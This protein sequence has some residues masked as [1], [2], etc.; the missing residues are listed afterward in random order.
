MN[1]LT[2]YYG[3]RDKISSVDLI[4]WR[5]NK[6]IGETIRWVTGQNVNHTSG[7]VWPQFLTGFPSAHVESSDPRLY[8]YEAAAEGMRLTYLSEALSKF[9]GQVFWVPLKPAYN[10]FRLQALNEIQKLDGKPYD[11]KS[12]VMNLWRRVRLGDSSVYCSEAWHIVFR[13]IGLIPPDFSPTG[14]PKH[15]GC[16][17]WPGEFEKTG[18]FSEPKRIL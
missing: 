10:S 8:V 4:E 13:N 2:N 5:S 17:L 12:L 14:K 16:G 1:D 7:A 18:L 15:A 6:P 9:D 3:V 11:F